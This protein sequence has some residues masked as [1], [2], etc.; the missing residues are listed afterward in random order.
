MAT[1][2]FVI[3]YHR[4]RC[5]CCGCSSSFVIPGDELPKFGYI[6]LYLDRKF[7]YPSTNTKFCILL[8]L[9]LLSQ[10]PS[11]DKRDRRWWSNMISQLA[12][13]WP[14]HLVQQTG[15]QTKSCNIVLR[16]LIEITLFSH[17]TFIDFLQHFNVRV[18]FIS[19]KVTVD[20]MV[21][22]CKYLG[23]A[24]SSSVWLIAI[25]ECSSHFN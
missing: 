17:F 11:S 23:M 7:W 15:N 10:A 16:S 24:P 4:S 8:T 18:S 21:V 1:L 25:G 3:T 9:L 6:I 14:R 13:P 5:C 20:G 19:F 12:L 2:N 22:I